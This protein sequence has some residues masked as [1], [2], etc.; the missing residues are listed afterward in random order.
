M[1]SALLITAGLVIAGGS[2]RALTSRLHRRR[3]RA[4]IS[5]D[6]AVRA[7]A[8]AVQQ[9]ARARDKENGSHAWQDALSG[10]GQ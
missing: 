7:H 5:P 9:L 4:M 2:I 6:D 1:L 10:F 8:E 3:H